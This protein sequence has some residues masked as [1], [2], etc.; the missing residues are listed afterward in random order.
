[1]NEEDKQGMIT[2]LSV[3]TGKP[4]SYFEDMEERRLVDE[5][6]RLLQIN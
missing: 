3:M 1:M 2:T 6:D 5:Y 4:E